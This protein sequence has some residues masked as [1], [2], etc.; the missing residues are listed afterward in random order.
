MKYQYST[1][2]P[3]KRLN[4]LFIRLSGETQSGLP[5]PDKRI[6]PYKVYPGIRQ[7]GTSG[8]AVPA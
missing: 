6:N 4:V 3:D 8:L 7:G 2:H 5:C 1:C